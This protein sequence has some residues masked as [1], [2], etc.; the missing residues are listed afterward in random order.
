MPIMLLHIPRSM[1]FAYLEFKK[2]AKNSE[3][4]VLKK[5][6]KISTSSNIVRNIKN[7]EFKKPELV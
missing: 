5:Y 6:G 1:R 4:N 3:S 2:A 7:S